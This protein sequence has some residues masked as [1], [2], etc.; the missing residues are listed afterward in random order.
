[1]TKE[2]VRTAGAGAWC[3]QDLSATVIDARHEGVDIQAGVMPLE[4]LVGPDGLHHPNIAIVNGFE[5]DG[6][7]AY[8]ASELIEGRTLVD[9]VD[10]QHRRRFGLERLPQLAAQDV[11]GDVVDAGVAKL[12]IAQP[13]HRVVFVESLLRLGGRLDV[14]LQQRAAARLLR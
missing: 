9:L 3:C 8:L 5:A 6:A 13:R 14:P 1:M 11:V 10:Q 7:V 4:V 12:R 2:I